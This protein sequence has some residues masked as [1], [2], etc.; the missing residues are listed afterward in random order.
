MIP[1]NFT[2]VSDDEFVILCNAQ[3]RAIQAYEATPCLAT[4]DALRE[5]DLAVQRARQW[6]APETA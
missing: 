4:I 6:R 2:H 3:A 5:A 1:K